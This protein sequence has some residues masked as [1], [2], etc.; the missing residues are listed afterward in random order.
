[1]GVDFDKKKIA[2]KQL[3]TGL[4]LPTALSIVDRKVYNA[5]FL[6][7]NRHNYLAPKNNQEKTK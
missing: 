7:I 3:N 1:M 5:L 4:S 2:G 6:Y